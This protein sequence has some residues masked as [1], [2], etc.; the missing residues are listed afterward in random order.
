MAV[1]ESECKSKSRMELSLMESSSIEDLSAVNK[2][3]SPIQEFYHGQG[4]FITGSTGFFGKLLLEKLLRL[5]LG[6]GTIFLLVRQKKNKNVSQRIEEIFDNPLFDK[7]KDEQPNFQD[8][9]IA[10]TGDCNHPNLGISS[11]DRA[12]LIREVS[13]VFHIAA[14]VKFN[15]K[16]KLAV[17]INVGGTKDVLNLCKEI[18]NLK[19]FVYV[20]TAYANCP[21]NV[22]EEKFYDAPMDSDKLL[23]LMECTDD[24][25]AE[26]ITPQLLGKWPN[27][28]T[29]TKAMAEDVIRKQADDLPIV[30]F[31]P[32]ITIST[33]RE[34]IRGWIDN[35]YGPTGILFSAG[36]GLLRSIHCDGSI[37][38]NVIPADLAINALI[39]CAWDAANTKYVYH[40]HCLFR[41]MNIIRYDVISLRHC[42][43]LNNDLPGD[44]PIYNY[45]SKDNPI[46]YNNVKEFFK[47]GLFEFPFKEAMWYYSFRLTKLLQS[48]KKIHTSLDVMD[49]FCQQEWAFTNDRVR[50]MIA[51]FTSNNRKNF[52]C[53]I[54]NLNWKVYFKRYARGVRVY[55]IKDPLDTLPQARAKWRRYEIFKIFQKTMRKLLFTHIL[56]NKLKNYRLVFD[57]FYLFPNRNYD[58]NWFRKNIAKFLASN[59]KKN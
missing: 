34:P 11:E 20:S 43:R 40:H 54:K 6:L 28:Y 1:I 30:I 49:Y 25:L 42:F 46:T 58:K 56:D 51:K 32:V 33:Y 52:D 35:L 21:Q 44:I 41:W 57:G 53:D 15:E 26:Y 23:T 10:I 45:V 13:I 37:T 4:I 39:A 29:F 59:L 31:R 8:R 47:E 17:T 24:K 50:A 55:L 38:I 48:Y 14:T 3:L 27:T 16:L 19:S 18:P 5:C 7:L 36:I 9:V 2:K 22:I 12:T